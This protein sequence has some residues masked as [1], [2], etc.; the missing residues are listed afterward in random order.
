MCVLV[1]SYMC[2][3]VCVCACVHVFVSVCVCACVH[4]FVSVC[5]CVPTL[6]L[7]FRSHSSAISDSAALS[8][9]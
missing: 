4:V 1:H 3:S 5:V 9:P 7:T 6:A 2:L 8:C